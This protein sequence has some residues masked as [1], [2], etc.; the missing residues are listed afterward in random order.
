MQAASTVSSSPIYKATFR[1]IKD[2]VSLR[3]DHGSTYIGELTAVSYNAQGGRSIDIVRGGQGWAGSSEL[4]LN[5][6]LT[7]NKI[8]TASFSGTFP[9]NASTYYSNYYYDVTLATIIPVEDY[10]NAQLLSVWACIGTNIPHSVI[11]A[12]STRVRINSQF[13]DIRGKSVYIKVSYNLN[14]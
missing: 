11:I 6:Y 3:I 1:S 4:H 12:D 5:D 14:V 10:D 2:D 8:R 13:A 9:T 7:G